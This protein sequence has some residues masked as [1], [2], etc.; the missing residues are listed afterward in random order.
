MQYFKMLYLL[1]FKT[2]FKYKNVEVK[3]YLLCD[4]KKTSNLFTNIVT[5]GHVTDSINAPLACYN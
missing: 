2:T 5:V 3:Q 1:W 4:S